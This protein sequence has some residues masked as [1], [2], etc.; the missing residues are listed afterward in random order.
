MM[1][2]DQSGGVRVGQAASES[3]FSIVNTKKHFFPLF[4]DF[5][6]VKGENPL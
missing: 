5:K 4:F 6:T 3:W 1:F 2:P